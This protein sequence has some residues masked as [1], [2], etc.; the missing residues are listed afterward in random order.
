MLT[1]LYN[2]H[3]EF[4]GCHNKNFQLIFYGIFPFCLLNTYFGQILEQPQGAWLERVPT[5]FVLINNLKIQY[6]PSTVNTSFNLY[7]VGF[8]GLNYLDMQLQ[9]NVHEPFMNCS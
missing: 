3:W 8:R 5:I 4:Y 1:Y 9:K 7:K 2:I 6:I